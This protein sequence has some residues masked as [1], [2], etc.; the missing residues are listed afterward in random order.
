MM[1]TSLKDVLIYNLTSALVRETALE[2][3]ARTIFSFPLGKN[4]YYFYCCAGRSFRYY[5]TSVGPQSSLILCQLLVEE[6]KH[7]NPLNLP[8]FPSKINRYETFCTRF[9]KASEKFENLIGSG[10]QVTV[11]TPSTFKIFFLKPARPNKA[12]EVY[13]SKSC[14]TVPVTLFQGTVKFFKTFENNPDLGQEEQHFNEAGLQVEKLVEHGSQLLSAT[15]GASLTFK[16]PNI[17]DEF[18]PSSS[19]LAETYRYRMYLMAVTKNKKG[20]I[21]KILPKVD[22]FTQHLKRVYLQ[23]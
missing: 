23:V 19:Q 11:L 4:E 20:S 16:K 1:K 2:T 14:N 3:W 8:I 12:E 15:Y 9:E 7:Q 17:P 10:I 22:A 6:T 13:S 5:L 18:K 21:A